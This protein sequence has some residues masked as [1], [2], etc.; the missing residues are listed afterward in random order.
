MLTLKRASKAL[1]E[2]KLA[3]GKEAGCQR[4][5]RTPKGY[6]DT[7]RINNRAHKEQIVYVVQHKKRKPM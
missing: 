7:T 6:V 3:S 1:Q 5:A 4:C 2:E